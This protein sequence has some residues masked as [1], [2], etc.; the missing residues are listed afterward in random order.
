M[1]EMERAIWA[2]AFVATAFR[3]GRNG[4]A[5]ICWDSADRAV[6]AYREERTFR[7]GRTSRNEEE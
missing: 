3:L 5:P 1:D 6:E 4:E 7:E 2:A